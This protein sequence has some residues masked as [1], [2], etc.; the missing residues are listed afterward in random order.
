MK[1]FK[2]LEEIQNERARSRDNGI[3]YDL[4]GVLIGELDRLPTRS[5]P[6]Q[7]DIY[8]QIVKL[9]NNAKE[10]AQ[11][12]N[13]KA[14][15]EYEYLQM[16]IKQQM[17]EQELTN[18]IQGYINEGF[19]NIGGIMRQLNTFHKGEFDGKMANKIIN[20]LLIK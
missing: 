3:I 2:T 6:S 1:E 18:V 10:M 16:F 8:K 4:L 14:I 13:E 15:M 12:K 20:E 17:D 19:S 7:D 5:K 9:Y 11:Y